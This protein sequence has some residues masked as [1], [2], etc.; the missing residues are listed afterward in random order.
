MNLSTAINLPDDAVVLRIIRPGSKYQGAIGGERT[1][2]NFQRRKLAKHENKMEPGLSVSISGVI[3]DTA[4]LQSFV[5][6]GNVTGLKLAECTV[7]SLRAAGFEVVPNPTKKN[8]AHAQL[9]C[10]SCD[11]MAIDCYPTDG[12]PCNLDLLAFQR[13]LADLFVPHAIKA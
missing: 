4:V 3:S 2:A 6:D 11:F 8:K 5:I 9:K 12:T 13:E 1:P 7:G 10:S